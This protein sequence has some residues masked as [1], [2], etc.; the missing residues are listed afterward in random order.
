MLVDC[1]STSSSSSPATPDAHRARRSIHAGRRHTPRHSETV[2][3][4]SARAPSAR[5]RRAPSAPLGWTRSALTHRGASVAGSSTFRRG[6]RRPNRRPIGRRAARRVPLPV[7]RNRCSRPSS[8]FCRNRS[9]TRAAN[10]GILACPLALTTTESGL[11]PPWTKPAHVHQQRHR[12][13]ESRSRPHVARSSDVRLTRRA[14]TVLSGTRRR[15]R[16]GG[17]VRRH[18]RAR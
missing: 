2:S 1:V 8:P 7:S 9:A 3:P 11:R 15:G 12:R 17:R 18:R 5:P 4:H 13:S 16:R 6:W 14:A 10:A